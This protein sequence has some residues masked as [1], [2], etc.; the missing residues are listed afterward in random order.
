MEKLLLLVHRIPFPP[1]KGDKV[2]SYHLLKYLAEHY[3]VFLGTFVDD[4]DDWQH[5]DKL[6]AMCADCRVESLDPRLGKLKSL[7]GMLTG[8]ALSLPFYRNAGMQRWVDDTLRTQGIDKAL[9]FSSQMA[10][11]LRR[12]PQ[13]TR[14]ADFVDIDSDKWAQYA[15]AKPWPV[16]WIYGR[17]AD[18]LRQFECAVSREFQAT[19]FVSVA[20]A[21]DYRKL[22]GLGPDKVTHVNNGVDAAYFDPA[23][24]YDNPYPA[25][26]PV[27]V[28]TGAMDYWPNIDAVEWFVR[29]TLPLLQRQHAGLRFYIAGARPAEQVKALAN[30]PG[31][32]VT[33]AV[34]DMRPYLRFADVSVAPLRIARGVQNKVLEAMAMARPVVASPQA[35][36]G[37]DAEAG[38]HFLVADAPAEFAAAVGRLLAGDAAMGTSARQCVLERYDW[39]KN[40][41]LFE[42]IFSAAN[43]AVPS[44]N[45]SR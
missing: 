43:Q 10:Q 30:V 15:Q 12:H 45:P 42:Q 17:E 37:I 35:A 41:A 33:G 24:P 11:Y 2:R 7:T 36:E 18:K 34:P 27:V 3:R 9:V 1:N 44:M 21:R 38:R 25:G 6:R 40:L 23:Q 20:E 32:F 22:S 14:I 16:S 13:L 39:Q 26:G 5:V 28:F 29:E 4:P 8:E 31:V 19:T